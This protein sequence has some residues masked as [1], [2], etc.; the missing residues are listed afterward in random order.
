MQ[1]ATLCRKT[2][3]A[4]CVIQWVCKHCNMPALKCHLVWSNSISVYSCC[5]QVHCGRYINEHMM[6]HGHDTS[7]PLTLSFFDLSVWCYICE[8]YIDN[9]VGW[10]LLALVCNKKSCCKLFNR[11]WSKLILNRFVLVHNL[12]SVTPTLCEACIK[13]NNL[14]TFIKNGLS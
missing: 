9:Q 2:G 5:L 7:H 14:I 3:C 8:A 4:W 6:L 13:P 11:F 1:N 10:I 12:S